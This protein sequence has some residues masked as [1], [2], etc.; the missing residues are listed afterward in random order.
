M[1][2]E[3]REYVITQNNNEINRVFA[4]SSNGAIKAQIKIDNTLDPDTLT[5]Y[6]HIKHKS[7]ITPEESAFCEGYALMHP[8][9]KKGGQIE[10]FK[11]YREEF[12]FSDR[13]DG[14]LH[15]LRFLP[16]RDRQDKKV[17]DKKVQANTASKS[18]QS[19]PI[20]GFYI[21]VFIEGMDRN[22][23]RAIFNLMSKDELVES[24]L[25]LLDKLEVDHD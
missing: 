25:N 21:N 20:S 15:N 10:F 1:K 18:R 23:R 4:Y 2:K 7:R 22:T 9:K 14:S 13:T 12:P 3:K 19:S 11:A 6:L 17:Q 5:A 16:D 8:S 24:C